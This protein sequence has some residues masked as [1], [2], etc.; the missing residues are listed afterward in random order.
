MNDDGGGG[1]SRTGFGEE[2]SEGNR[3]RRGLLGTES[4]F[5]LCGGG[6]GEKN[7]SRGG[8]GGGGF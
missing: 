6:C 5:V 7:F 8:E 1:C 3:N 2:G 4:G